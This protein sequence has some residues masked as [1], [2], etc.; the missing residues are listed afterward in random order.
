MFCTIIGFPLLRPR[1]VP[2]WRSFFKKKKLHIKMNSLEIHPK[3]LKFKL[4]ELFDNENFLASAVTMPYKKNLYSRVIVKDK[5]TKFAQSVNFLLKK[6]KNIYGFNTDVY[7]ALD[8]IKKFTKRKIVIYGYGGA[9]ESITRVLNKIYKKSKISVITSQKRPKKISNRID[10]LKRG[11]KVDL[12]NVDI[13]INCSPLGSNLKKK[14]IKK[15]P[16]NLRD[17]SNAN[18]KIR[19]FD[20]V[21]KPKNNL[22]KKICK[23][24]NIYYV[25]GLNMNTIQA[26]L[27]LKKVSEYYKKFKN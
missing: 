22:L 26:N 27:A 17:L 11:D 23:K 15:S 9:G 21:Y 12:S 20:I 6:N 7:G 1:S 25:N 14:F 13:F 18:P 24:K 8:T 4:R 19:V 2:L 3:K 16:L 10:F 5:L